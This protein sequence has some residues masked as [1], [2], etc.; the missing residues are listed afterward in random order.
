M[1]ELRIRAATAG[2][3]QQL[4]DL[5]EDAQQWLIGQGTDQWANNTREKMHPRFMRSIEQG[6][7]YIA[8]NDAGLVGMVTVDEYAD[9]EFWRPEDQPGA[10][11]YVH[12]MVVDR[13]SAGRGIGGALLN[14]AAKV[15]ASKGRRWLRLDA[16]RTNPALHGYYERQG[17]TPVRVAEL[18]HRG[19]GALFQRSVNTAS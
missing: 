17:F 6:E 5:Y 13:A 4:L 15:A 16:W 9:P 8:E 14:W 19:S 11:L 3:V 7:C 18:A 12:R 2:D 1:S 10:A